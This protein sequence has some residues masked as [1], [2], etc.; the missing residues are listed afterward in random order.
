MF[1]AVVFNAVL[2]NVARS[3]EPHVWGRSRIGRF[4][5]MFL[6]L[7]NLMDFEPFRLRIAHAVKRCDTGRIV[8]VAVGRNSLP[9]D[10]LPGSENGIHSLSS[11][12]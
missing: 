9:A 12:A 4:D 7:K 3:S 11:Y 6:K 1:N 10:Q 2:F 8:N 5:G